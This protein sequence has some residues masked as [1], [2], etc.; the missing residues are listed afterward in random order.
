MPSPDVLRPQRY[1]PPR[2]WR[3]DKRNRQMKRGATAKRRS[4]R[5]VPTRP[6]Q[7]RA[8]RSSS[9]LRSEERRVGKE[10]SV[11]VD[12]GGR[13]IIKKKKQQKKTTRDALTKPK[14]KKTT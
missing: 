12:L 13:R 2:T 3:E 10:W 14:Q 4:S 11:R 5:S 8:R 9:Q 7:Q 6:E 1:A